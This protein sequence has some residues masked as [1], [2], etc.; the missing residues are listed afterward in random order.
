MPLE[1][2]D[3][4]NTLM[5]LVSRNSEAPNINVAVAATFVELTWIAVARKQQRTLAWFRTS[6]QADGFND[7]LIF[8]RRKSKI[9]GRRLS[10]GID[11]IGMRRLRI[12]PSEVMGRS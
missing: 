6:A 12:T 2:S 7:R 8:E 3:L 1:R 4:T 5:R 11:E 10:S 9:L